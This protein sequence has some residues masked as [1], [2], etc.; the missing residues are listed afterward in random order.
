MKSVEEQVA[1]L[2]V[3]KDQFI[4]DGFPN[5]ADSVQA[6]INTLQKNGATSDEEAPQWRRRKAWQDGTRGALRN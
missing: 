5:L 2:E 4:R 1:E 6:T 3:H